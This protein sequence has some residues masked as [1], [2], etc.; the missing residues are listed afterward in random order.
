MLTKFSEL[1][2]LLGKCKKLNSPIDIVILC[3]T[4]LITK[5]RTNKKGGELY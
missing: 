3:E 5:D 2:A 4:C 1:N